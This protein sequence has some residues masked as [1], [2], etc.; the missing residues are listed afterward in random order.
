MAL[1]P[2]ERH[3]P[4]ENAADWEKGKGVHAR[5]RH[6][7]R[8]GVVEFN[9]DP[10]H[11][12][13]VMVRTIHDGPEMKI[14]KPT[15]PRKATFSLG[16][17]NPMFSSGAGMD[18]GSFNVPPVGARVFVMYEHGD[19]ES[20][21]YFGGWFAHSPE[22]RR[23]GAT[24]TTLT[25]PNKR[26]PEDTGYGPDGSSGGDFYYPPRPTR[27]QGFW[28]EQQGPE[29]PLELAEMVDHTPDTQMYFKTLK[30]A[31]LIIK[32]RD[33]AEELILTD[34]LGA[35]LRFE[36][37]TSL[38]ED[39]V[40]RRGRA[41]ATQHEP[42]S[43]DNAAYDRHRVALLAN[44]R[45]GLEI[46][47]SASEDDSVILQSHL[48]TAVR[49]NVHERHPDRVSVE[50]DPGEKRL[51]ILYTEDGVEKGALTFD[52][53]AQK[54]QVKGLDNLSLV[55]DQSVSIAAQRVEI[56]GDLD[57]NGDIRHWTNFSTSP[58]VNVVDRASTRVVLKEYK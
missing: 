13:R 54:L 26:K 52:L 36:S 15:D 7:I 39:G 33:E 18:F 47:N 58:G 27:Y 2:Y 44:N 40:L 28:N 32:E 34:R 14:T 24:E 56:D 30:G 31:S 11:R 17:C 55:S 50:L 10:D 1:K 37:H 42:L 21:V 53:V 8:R 45:S 4:G 29:R 49:K 19:P 57:V 51:Q 23:Y 6:D 5:D 3:G 46:V 16:W 25:P 9:R 41:S 43:L 20:G 12:G 38:L 22:P 48:G 35:E